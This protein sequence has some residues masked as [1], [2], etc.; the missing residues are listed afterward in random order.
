M[1]PWFT[2]LPVPADQVA[3]GI[4]RAAVCAVAAQLKAAV[5]E[6][7]RALRLADQ[8][9]AV[10]AAQVRETLPGDELAHRDLADVQAG[11]VGLHTQAELHRLGYQLAQCYHFGKPVAEPD[12]AGV[13]VPV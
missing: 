6:T 2:D 7:D 13:T 8:Q 5:M 11:A 9:E 1:Q 4:A 10:A 12:F 3:G